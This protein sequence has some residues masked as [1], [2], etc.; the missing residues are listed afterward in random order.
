MLEKITPLWKCESIKYN[1][2]LVTLTG[3]RE[4]NRAVEK[5]VSIYMFVNMY[6]DVYA[7][8]YSFFI[9]DTTVEE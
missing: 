8:F 4:K 5:H 2:R 1:E 3:I 6:F 9:G 7:L